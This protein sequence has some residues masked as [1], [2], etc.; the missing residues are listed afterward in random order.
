MVL[1]LGGGHRDHRIRLAA[2]FSHRT[3]VI[4]AIVLAGRFIPAHEV[5][6]KSTRWMSAVHSDTAM[7]V[8]SL[9]ALSRRAGTAGDPLRAPLS[10]SAAR[11][12]ARR[13]LLLERRVREPLV[14]PDT[15]ATQPCRTCL[16]KYHSMAAT[17]VC[18]FCSTLSCSASCIFLPCN[19]DW[20]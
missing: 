6:E 3:V 15:I 13:I 19:R 10:W 4:A 12:G 14:P 1:G 17:A 9:S 11:V 2:V 20:A 8:L 16:G 7:V 18:S 5:S